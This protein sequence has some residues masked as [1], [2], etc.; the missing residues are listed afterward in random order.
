MATGRGRGAFGASTWSLATKL[1]VSFCLVVLVLM[2][3]VTVYSLHNAEKN[4]RLEERETLQDLAG[5]T[6]GRLDQLIID[7]KQ[8]V[9]VL[10]G[11]NELETV[12]SWDL[13]RRERAVH[14]LTSDAAP[15]GDGY[16]MRSLSDGVGDLYA[17]VKNEED[18]QRFFKGNGPDDEYVWVTIT[19]AEGNLL[20]QSSRTAKDQ[21]RGVDPK[22]IVPASTLTPADRKKRPSFN[23]AVVAPTKA[24]VG[25]VQRSTRAGV[26]TSYISFS[27]AVVSITNGAVLGVVTFAIDWKTVG[28]LVRELDDG[29]VEVARNDGTSAGCRDGSTSDGR[30][31]L[32]VDQMGAVLRPYLGCSPTGR[33]QF[34][35]LDAAGRDAARA[36]AKAGEYEF[37]FGKA[38]EVT[39]ADITVHGAET[40]DGRLREVSEIERAFRG[41]GLAPWAAEA[42][43]KR[44]YT[45]A[46]AWDGRSRLAGFYPV[47][48]SGA[49]GWHVIFTEDEEV[50]LHQARVE[51]TGLFLGMVAALAV[52]SA[53][54]IWLVRIVTRQTKALMSGTLALAG[55]ALET[56]IPVL[57]GDELG[58]LAESFNEMA[59]KL[60]AAH[61]KA[62]EEKRRA[63]AARDVAEEARG[64][65][66]KSR[67]AAEDA[68]RAKSTF[69]AAMSHELRTPL[70]AII[71]YGEMLAEDA[72]DDGRTKEV[73]DLQKIVS[74]GKH[75]LGLINDILDLEKVDAGKMVVHCENVQVGE[76][77]RDVV[78]T[79]KPLVEKNGNS[80]QVNVETGFGAL[81]ADAQKLRQSL[82]NLLS[83][84]SK[85]T[86][87]GTVVLD[88]KRVGDSAAFAVTDTGIG[89]TPEQLARLFQPFVQADSSTSRKYGGTGL[90]LALTRKFCELMGGTVSV[91]S[92]EGVGSTFT[93]LLP[94]APPAAASASIHPPPV[95]PAPRPILVI[96]DDPA[97]QDL[98]GRALSKEGYAVETALNG[99]EGLRKARALQ[100]AAI[101]LDV[102]MPGMD[103][104]EV[105]KALEAD[106][107]TSAIPVIL[108]TMTDDRERGFSLGASEFMTKPFDRD[109][110]V[111]VLER[112][113]VVPSKQPI[114]I[115]EDDPANRDLIRRTLEKAGWVVEEAENGEVALAR[116]EAN[117]PS[118]VLLDLMMPQVDG[119]DL[120]ARIREREDLRKIP[121]VVITAK[122]LTEDERER[123]T[124]NVRQVLQKG[125]YSRDE[126]LTYVRDL[127]AEQTRNAATPTPPAGG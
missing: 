127:V 63:D 121:V 50:W 101:T 94:L 32:L 30:Q 38:E 88:V 122:D 14:S 41:D 123:V 99:E 71:G 108:I 11:D 26:L 58:R 12:L 109:R 110:L 48:Q 79:V 81:W 21:G 9:E 107:A 35:F 34:S 37:P 8:R 77:V 28:A 15:D 72:S 120:L 53:V 76:I 4:Q 103:G 67:T 49:N 126:L 52:A 42:T 19:D 83:N 116:I 91:S 60:N 1:S 80:I 55:G 39:D 31:V 93:I 16:V 7:S 113:G 46:F 124:E 89:M 82:L 18:I 75:L 73:E 51:H 10:A 102:V 54:M 57:S 47:R 23:G 25:N 118:L 96:D 69:L 13:A 111:A 86:D 104:L 95:S 70:N 105:L 78:S 22:T 117:R 29:K 106:P 97:M 74:A 61:D 64:Q 5:A 100:P 2:A 112:M 36:S 90:G 84:A 85:F 119:F 33:P 45:G 59:A 6:A 125:K 3:G 20:L 65:A 114:L 24:Y 43:R 115:V 68:N 62:A 40:L 56:R 17:S 98:I 27:H 66:E 44:L 92:R 87:K